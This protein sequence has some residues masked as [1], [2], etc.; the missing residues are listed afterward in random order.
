[1]ANRR[2]SSGDVFV[3]YE[4]ETQTETGWTR[5]IRPL[6]GKGDKNYCMACCD[7]GLVHEIQFRVRKVAGRDRVVFRARRNEQETAAVRKEDS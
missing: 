2:R 4:K 3:K 6:H 7:C 1:M 5:W